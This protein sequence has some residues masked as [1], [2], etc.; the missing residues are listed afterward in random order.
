MENEYEDEERRNRKVLCDSFRDLSERLN[1]TACERLLRSAMAEYPHSPVPHNLMGV[2]LEYQN[3]H[4][5]AMKH[6]RAAWALDPT[7]LPARLNLE[8]YS[9]LILRGPYLIDE[10]DCMAA[11]TRDPYKIE[12]D[13]HGI[14]HVL[15]RQGEPD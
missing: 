10:G 3:N 7:Y 13:E 5:A 14:G 15:K 6:F 8:H 1:Y 11:E 4:P 9:S 2:L 12:Y